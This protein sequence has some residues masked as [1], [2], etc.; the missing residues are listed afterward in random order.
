M[1]RLACLLAALLAAVVLAGCGVGADAVERNQ[2]FVF[3]APGG[4]TAITYDPPESRRPVSGIEG[5]SLLRPDAIAALADYPGRVVVVNIWG[6]WCGPCREEVLD[7]QAVADQMADSGVAVLG[8]D[9]KDERHS[10]A[11]FLTARGVRYD[12]IFDPAGR[13]LLGLHGFPRNVVPSTVVFD[14]QHRVAAVFLAQVSQVQ[15]RPLLDRL[16]AEPAA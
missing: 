6:S 5:E 15:L 7:L 3:V 11:D 12:S 2:E 9:V 14:K 8:I 16:V 10:A 13:S 4:Q 1:R